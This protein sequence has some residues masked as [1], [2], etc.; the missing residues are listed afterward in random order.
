MPL[1]NIAVHLQSTAADDVRYRLGDGETI[2]GSLLPSITRFC[3][4]H[5]FNKQ[6]LQANQRLRT[7][8][9]RRYL[10]I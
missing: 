5:A 2:I 8:T 1:A 9:G 4:I 10:S 6:Q 3:K 7:H